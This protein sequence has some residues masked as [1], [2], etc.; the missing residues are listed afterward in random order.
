MKNEYGFVRI[1]CVTPKLKLTDIEY[2]AET[3]ISA[4]EKSA[5]HKPDILVFP[6]L[7]LTGYSC[8][9]LFAQELLYEKA[10]ASLLKIIEKTQTYDFIITIGL[11]LIIES[12]YYNCAAIVQSGKILGIV[13][14]TFLPNHGEFYEQRWFSSG[15]DN[16]NSSVCIDKKDVPF[17]I[18][19][20]I[21]PFKD[22]SYTIGF[23]ICEDLWASIP[24][25]SKMALSGANVIINLSASNEL[26]GKSEYRRNLIKTHS[27]QLLCIYAYC[28]SGMFESTTDT[29][30]G[31]HSI[32]AENG[33]ILEESKRFQNNEILI[34]AD[35]DI[36]FIRHERIQNSTFSD[37]CKIEKTNFR[38]IYGNSLSNQ[39]KESF[40]STAKN[41]FRYVE[42]HPFIPSNPLK[43]KER[44]KEIFSIQSTALASRLLHINCKKAI[45]G[46]S[47]GLDSTLALLVCIEAFKKINYCLSDI[48]CLNMPGFGTTK[49][50]KSNAIKLCNALSIPIETISINKAVRQHFRDISHDES[51]H[52]ITYENAQ[53]RERTK[54]LMN[55]ANQLGGIVIGT[56]DLSELAMGWCTYNGDHMS[57]YAVNTGVPKTLVRFLVEFYI[58]EIATD[59]TAKIL[60]DIN[61]TPI[62]PELLPP[63]GN[64]E[65]SQKTEDNIGP[66]ELHD[67]FLYQVVR[68]G[69]APQKVLFLAKAA[70]GASYSEETIKKWLIV[71]YKRFFSQQFKRSCMPDGPKVGTIALSPRADWRMPSDASVRLWIKEL[72]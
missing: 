63:L 59:K 32:I 50:T 20:L 37:C 71:F 36:D 52:N 3:I 61:N 42:K 28:S 30:F 14:K 4:V 44:C 45:I 16:T 55:K 29:V 72:E 13:P 66:Y 47:G 68:C 41:L 31:G 12:K 27:A 5:I 64:D 51:I 43:R 60:N 26:V 2:N 23:E 10:L 1:G 9:D 54:I 18:D 39:S 48:Q 49:R 22:S 7:S 6:E 58:K 56:G 53:A 40:F 15:L 8:A 21:K 70:F 57:M 38:L 19:L 62:S 33:K 46:L 35:T 69:F 67:F 17:G 34:F 65:I 25:S 11:P 24:P